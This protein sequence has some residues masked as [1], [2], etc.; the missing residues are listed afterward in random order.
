MTNKPVFGFL[1]GGLC[2]A[3]VLVTALVGVGTCAQSWHAYN[4]TQPSVTYGDIYSA[5][6]DP[7]STK[8][9]QAELDN[10]VAYKALQKYNDIFYGP[11]STGDNWYYWS[12]MWLKGQEGSAQSAGTNAAQK[13]AQNVAPNAAPNTYY[14]QGAV[15][16]TYYM[17]QNDD[18]NKA[19]LKAYSNKGSAA[20]QVAGQDETNL[21][22]LLQNP[23][24][25]EGPQSNLDKRVAY[26]ALQKYND[27]YYGPYST[28]DNWF[29]WSNMWLKGT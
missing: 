24:A 18:Q 19:I 23:Y 4:S 21:Y 17:I 15:S 7:Y 5:L 9:P 1:A 20:D 29:Y 16:N 8:G 27:I 22:K 12:N 14:L 6:K 28:G 10:K 2:L 11:Y 25:F 13:A 26:K 3:V